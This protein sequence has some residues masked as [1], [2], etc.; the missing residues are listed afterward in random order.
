[1]NKKGFVKC[2]EIIVGMNGDVCCPSDDCPRLDCIGRCMDINAK[3]AYEKQ[4]REALLQ[5]MFDN[6]EIAI[7]IRYES[8][9]L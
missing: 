3:C 7:G 9:S 8:N 1:M 2:G 4:R 6:D 5:C